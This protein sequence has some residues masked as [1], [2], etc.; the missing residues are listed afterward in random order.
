MPGNIAYPEM[1]GVV[2]RSMPV[3]A[4]PADKIREETLLTIWDRT[5]YGAG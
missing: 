1:L 3:I 4:A 2:V 5:L